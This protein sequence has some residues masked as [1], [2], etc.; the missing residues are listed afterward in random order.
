MIEYEER[1][2]NFF[3]LAFKVE[4]SVCPKA[5]LYSIPSVAFAAFIMMMEVDNPGLKDDMGINEINRS[6]IWAATTGT[7]LALLIFR[8]NRAMSRF[9]EGT[10]LLHQMRGEWF[11]S[12]SCCVTFSRPAVA[13]KPK[14]VWE[15]RHTIVRLM[16]LCHGSA[17]EEIGDGLDQISTI[18][19]FGLDDNTLRHLKMSKEDL[20]FN[21]VEVVLHMIQT[22]ITNGLDAGILLIPA[23]ILSRV[24]Q[25]L[26]RG[27]VNLLNAKKIADTRFP[28]PYAQ[29]IAMLLVLHSFL[30]PMMLTSLFKDSVAMALVTSFIPPFGFFALNLTSQELENPF[31]SDSND[32]PLEDFQQEMN[33][34]LLMLLHQNAD[35]LP[36]LNKDRCVM[37]FDEL[38]TLVL[39][40]EECPDHEPKRNKS[41]W[42]RVQQKTP[43]QRL[44]EI[45]ISD[46]AGFSRCTTTDISNSASI[47]KYPEKVCDE[48]G[49]DLEDKVDPPDV[50]SV[51]ETCANRAV[52]ISSSAA[53]SSNAAVPSLA[54]IKRTPANLNSRS[55]VRPVKDIE[56]ATTKAQRATDPVL[57]PAPWP[58]GQHWIVEPEA[59]SASGN[60][61][62]ATLKEF[63]ETLQRATMLIDTQLQSISRPSPRPRNRSPRSP[64]QHLAA[65]GAE[66]HADLTGTTEALPPMTSGALQ[67]AA[68]NSAEASL[69]GGSVPAD[70]VER[71]LERLRQRINHELAQDLASAHARSAEL[72][73]SFSVAMIAQAQ[74]TGPTGPRP[75]MPT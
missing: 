58:E 46:L 74:A 38:H 72:I 68:A 31:G 14:E 15:F 56:P 18:D 40:K 63:G 33:T 36:G 75:S 43:N 49:A 41:Y 45:D 39:R 17:L 3:M 55:G 4:G 65:R 26:S 27:F 35:L 22:I 52:A 71:E 50:A 13:Q 28:F 30:I 61:I 53:S 16:S 2:Y 21:R 59:G 47:S 25:T 32:L 44:S 1:W 10:G 42:D 69:T 6:Q 9:W 24:Y 51:Q 7:L 11:D 34:C 73:N 20:K 66:S 8:T 62:S 48:P 64:L 5:V 57:P 54:E 12:V 67:D 23:P 29:L 60:N 19:P 70:D 37:D